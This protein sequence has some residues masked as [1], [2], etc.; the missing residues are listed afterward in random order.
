MKIP[1]GRERTADHLG[2][3]KKLVLFVDLRKFTPQLQS[4]GAS[5]P[6]ISIQSHFA[7][8]KQMK[9]GHLTKL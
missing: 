3:W 8:N 9:T 4:Q 7:N 5:H 2:S 1:G 6:I